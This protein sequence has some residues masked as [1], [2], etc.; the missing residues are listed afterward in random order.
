MT[1][2]TLATASRYNLVQRVL[3]WAVA[4]LVI[5]SLIGGAF[6]YAFGFE[7]LRDTFGMAATNAIYKY[8]KTSGVMILGLMAIRVAVRAGM[9]A[10]PPYAGLT[11]FERMASQVSHYTLY[12]A[13]VAMPVT[14]WLATAA[15]GFPVEFFDLTLPGLIAKNPPLSETLFLVHGILGLLI[16]AVAAVHIAAAIRHWKVKEDGVMRRMSLLG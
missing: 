13:L 10:P 7:G 8:H 6:L 5:L 15:G 1:D 12:A 11:G 9:G 3:H 4:V 16:L 2:A 14:G